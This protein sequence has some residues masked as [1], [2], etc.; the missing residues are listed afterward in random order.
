VLDREGDSELAGFLSL[1]EPSKAMKQEAASAGQYEY[2]NVRYDRIQMLTVKDI[3]EGKREFH[4]PTK[5]GTKITTRQT[6][7]PLDV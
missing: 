4:T 5:I 7:L 1:H 6:S 3:I 2:Q